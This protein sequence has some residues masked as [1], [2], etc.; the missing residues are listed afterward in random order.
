MR[1]KTATRLQ[2]VVWSRKR[3]VVWRKPI[4]LMRSG[5]NGKFK[6]S[7]VADWKAKWRATSYLLKRPLRAQAPVSRPWVSRRWR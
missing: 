1:S 5:R 3:S 6:L 7:L 4:W 2:S